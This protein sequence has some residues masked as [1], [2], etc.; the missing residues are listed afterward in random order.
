MTEAQV[1]FSSGVKFIESETDMNV[2]LK[3]FYREIQQWIDDGCPDHDVFRK[4]TAICLSLERWLGYFDRKVNKILEDSFNDAGL[5]FVLPFNKDLGEFEVEML[6]H[7]I[8]KNPARLA[9]I[10]EHAA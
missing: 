7:S 6:N 5:D 1:F 2:E 4:T 3:Q 9:W 10:K 8:Y